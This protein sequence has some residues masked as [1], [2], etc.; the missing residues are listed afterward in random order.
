MGS[1]AGSVGEFYQPVYSAV[2]GGV[3]AFTKVLAKDLARH[4]KLGDQHTNVGLLPGS[5]GTQRF[6]RLIGVR[7]AKELLME[8]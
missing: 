7:K 8:V 6:P 5:G 2:K 3:V 1:D 4:A